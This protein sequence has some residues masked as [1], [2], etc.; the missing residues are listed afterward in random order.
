MEEH[1]DIA[2]PQILIVV[3]TY[4]R[5]MYTQETLRTLK[6]NTTVPHKVIVVDNNSDDGTQRWLED[7][8]YTEKLYDQVILNRMNRYPGAA[9]NQGWMR[10]LADHSNAPF[11]CRLDNDCRMH[12]EWAQHAIECFNAFDNLGQFGLIE[13]SDAKEFR[14]EVV[15]V[16]GCKINVG[17]TNI[18]GPMM[19]RRELWDRGLRYSELPWH[20]VGGPTPQEDVLMSLKVRELGFTFANTTE[21]IVTEMSFG[22]TDEYFDYYARTFTERGHGVPARTRNGQLVEAGSEGVR[23]HV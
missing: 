4:N 21:H 20:S 3:P 16:D 22:N 18:G 2:E 5:L 14:Y 6:A 1:L 13:M 9:C 8:A 11:L 12:V 15:E 7:Q 23:D 19:I 10:L 17:P